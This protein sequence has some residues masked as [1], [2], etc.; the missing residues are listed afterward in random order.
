MYTVFFEI[1]IHVSLEVELLC[2][3]YGYCVLNFK[4]K[5]Q[6]FSKLHIPVYTLNY[7]IFKLSQ[8]T[9]YHSEREKL[10]KLN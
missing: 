10:R 6:V 5:G 2:H 1:N 9:F 4:S 3:E 7:T 8:S